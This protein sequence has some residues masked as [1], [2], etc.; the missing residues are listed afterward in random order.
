MQAAV[1][2]TSGLGK[3]LGSLTKKT[4]KSLI[5]FNNTT[6][7][8]QII[9]NLLQ[10]KDM[11]KI[12]IITGYK[13]DDFIFL[14]EK[15]KNIIELINNDFYLQYQS[16]YALVTLKDVI[17]KYENVFLI[18]GDFVMLENCF[19]NV[20]NQSIM[21]GMHNNNNKLD[22][23]YLLNE[24]GNII[25]IVKDNNNNN[26]LASE[27]SHINKKWCQLLFSD[28][29]N[30]EE[31]EK[32]KTKILGKYLIENAIKNNIDLKPYIINY[33]EFWDLDNNEDLNRLK[34]KY[35]VEY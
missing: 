22:W 5:K 28:L 34:N 29:Q 2:F 4:H 14:K 8:E 7:I 16:G 13:K 33:D 27:W 11:K 1:I 35:L 17:S 31:Q 20:K 9:E 24:K 23:R 32:L 3:R 6:I 19:I 12:I 30:I 25:D 26:Y 10:V 15:Y 21:A 18:S